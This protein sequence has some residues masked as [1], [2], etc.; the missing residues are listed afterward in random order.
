MPLESE[1]VNP[2]QSLSER[3]L[4]FACVIVLFAVAGLY[5]WA[6]YTFFHPGA[7]W[8]H[9]AW[10]YSHG[11]GVTQNYAKA[12]ELYERSAGVGNTNALARR[13][14]IDSGPLASPLLTLPLD[15]RSL[16]RVVRGQCLL[17]K[18][19]NPQ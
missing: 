12:R 17:T 2:K 6:R 18:W 9:Q 5:G 14:L 13:H 4:R 7:T 1:P 11:N 10:Q 8:F 19:Q 16:Y 15:F 3:L